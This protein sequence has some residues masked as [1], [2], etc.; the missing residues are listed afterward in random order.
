M[1]YEKYLRGGKNTKVFEEFK[2]FR[3]KIVSLMND[4]RDGYTRISKKHNDSHVSPKAYWLGLQIFFNYK[5]TMIVP[6]LFYEN[7]F[8]TDFTKKAELYNSFF[9]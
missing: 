4:L 6:P 7:R 8:V 1:F 2:L 5:K 9:S 3:N